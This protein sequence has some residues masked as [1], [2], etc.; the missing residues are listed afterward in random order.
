MTIEDVAEE[1]TRYNGIILFKPKPGAPL[2]QQIA[3]NSTNVGAYELL[4]LQMRLLEDISGVHG[5][6]QGKPLHRELPPPFMHNKPKM[7]V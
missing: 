3:V 5:A 4:N 1:W 6:M 7:Q 2:P